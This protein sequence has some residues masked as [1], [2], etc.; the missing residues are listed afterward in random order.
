MKERINIADILRD[1][2]KGT[3]LYSPICGNVELIEVC[4]DSSIICESETIKNLS[5]LFNEDGSMFLG[6]EIERIGECLLFPSK[7]N[8]EWRTRA[9][10]KNP[11]YKFEPFDKVLVRNDDEDHWCPAFFAYEENYVGGDRCYGVIAGTSDPEFLYQ[12]IPYNDKT[13]HLVGTT[14]PYEE[15]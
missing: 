6:R 12:C 2:P 15:Q 4:D 8:R 13:K 10:L 1:Y 9:K 7:E 3:L 14:L 5:L 11:A